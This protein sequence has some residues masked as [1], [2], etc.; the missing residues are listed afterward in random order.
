MTSVNIDTVNGSVKPKKKVSS[1][2]TKINFIILDD[3]EEFVKQVTRKDVLNNLL[4]GIN[5][6]GIELFQCIITDNDPSITIDEKR[7]GF[8]Y[9]TMWELLIALKC[10]K[11]LDYTELCDGQ[12]QS[13]SKI[14]KMNTILR[15]KIVNGNNVSDVTIKQGPT[16]IPISIKYILIISYLS[17]DSDIIISPLY[18]NT[19]LPSSKYSFQLLPIND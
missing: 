19:I 13:L 6:S 11:R 1:K 17:L 9:E 15:K 14:T 12:L 8:L 5:K 4:N 3:E 7:Q 10:I 18:L 2:N 16:T